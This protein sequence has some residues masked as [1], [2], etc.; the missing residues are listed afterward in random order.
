MADPAAVA[1]MIAGVAARHGRLDALVNTAG[2]IDAGTAVV[3]QAPE[4][5]RSL[6][7]L[8]L[9]G[10]ATAARA[11]AAV[12]RGQGGG[13]IVNVASGAAQRSAPFR[14]ATATARPKPRSSR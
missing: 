4:A 14:C 7:A 9:D 12:M 13:A 3:D 1:A 2:R 5:F 11:A 8:N 10:A 6:L